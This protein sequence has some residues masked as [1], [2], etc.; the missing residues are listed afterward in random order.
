[1]ARKAAK[2][3]SPNATI[4]SLVVCDD[5]RQEKSGKWIL[6]GVYDKDVILKEFPVI[7]TKLVFR[8][9]L[10]VDV[11]KPKQVR[12][13]LVPNDG[14][15]KAKLAANITQAGRG[16]IVT[17]GFEVRNIKLDDE[18]TIRIFIGLD[19]EPRLIGA[20][21]VRKPHASEGDENILN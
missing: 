1:M 5:A 18:D 7:L 10:I 15:D 11:E 6:I 13:K 17:L 16:D 20:I 8:V 14:T 9:T 2:K 4:T 3:K 12:F 19:D 21:T